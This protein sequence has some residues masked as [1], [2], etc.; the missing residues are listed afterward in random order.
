MKRHA[1][2]AYSEFGKTLRDP[3][4]ATWFGWIFIAAIVIFPVTSFFSSC[5]E[6]STREAIEVAKLE[7]THGNREENRGELLKW[8]VSRGVHP[9]VARC[10]IYALPRQQCNWMISDLEEDERATIT[11][12]LANPFV[13]AVSPQEKEVISSVLP[14]NPQVYVQGLDFGG[15]SPTK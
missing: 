14:I 5:S 2:E 4:F 9:L 11:S 13:E 3:T 10:A 12:M 1:S 6:Q 7:A 8:M 15:V